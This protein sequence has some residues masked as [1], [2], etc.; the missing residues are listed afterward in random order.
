MGLSPGSLYIACEYC[1]YSYLE[2]HVLRGLGNA[3]H[4]RHAFRRQSR[5]RALTW[6]NQ[7]KLR[8]KMGIYFNEAAIKIAT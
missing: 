3:A 8:V 7:F 4:W 1:K 2:A 6:A 5:G